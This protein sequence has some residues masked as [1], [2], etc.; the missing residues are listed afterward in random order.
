MLS[1]CVC[2]HTKSS[3]YLQVK[4][5]ESAP[6]RTLP[7]PW[8]HLQRSKCPC[9]ASQLPM[10]NAHCPWT[11]PLCGVLG[12]SARAWDCISSCFLPCAGTA[13]LAASLQAHG[14]QTPHLPSLPRGPSSGCWGLLALAPPLFSSQAFACAVSSFWSTVFTP[15]KPNRALSGKK[16]RRAG[17]SLWRLTD[18]AQIP[19]PVLTAIS[20]G[21]IASSL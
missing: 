14:P 20:L 1:G 21:K 9:L 5:F 18:T 13:R 3:E 4:C 12:P 16:R 15:R 7:I 17:G 8:A 10:D 2:K 19:A 11:M 6:G